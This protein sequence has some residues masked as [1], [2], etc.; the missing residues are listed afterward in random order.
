MSVDMLKGPDVGDTE[1][2]T[3]HLH[4]G[5]WVAES[6]WCNRPIAERSAFV[7]PRGEDESQGKLP[8][9]GRLVRIG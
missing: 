5:T 7:F 3:R 8:M 1:A 6:Q 4:L 9:R 2:M